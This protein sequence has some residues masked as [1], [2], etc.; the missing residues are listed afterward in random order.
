MRLI[1]CHRCST[2]MAANAPRCPLCGC[3]NEELEQG[4]QERRRLFVMLTLLLLTYALFLAFKL[5]LISAQGVLDLVSI[6][7]QG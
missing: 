2:L 4:R 7:R 3:R 6:L 1:N 5:E